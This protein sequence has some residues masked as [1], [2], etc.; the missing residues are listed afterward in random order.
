MFLLDSFKE[1]IRKEHLDGWLFCNF[2]HRDTLT[3]TLLDLDSSSVSTRRWFYFIPATGNPLKIVHSIESGILDQLPGSVKLYSQRDKL[4]EILSQFAN[5]NIAVLSDPNIHVLSTM[6]AS[7]YLLLSQVKINLCS[8]STLIQRIKGTLTKEQYLLHTR[9]ASILYKAVMDSWD[10]INKALHENTD[11]YEGDIQ[12]LMTNLFTQE[13]LITDHAPI[14]AF[15][16][17]SSDPHYTVPKA[18]NGL[19]HRGNKVERQQ[20]VQ[21]DLW[22]KYPDGVYADISWIGYTDY[23]A[24][25]LISDYFT[26]V[27]TA[28]DLVYTAIKAAFDKNQSITGADCD[29]I[30]RNFLLQKVSPLAV[31]HRTGHGIDIDCH[32]SGVNLD[33]IEF[34][35]YRK[36][37]EGS[38][39]SVEPGIYLKDFGFRTEINIAIV[40]GTAQV[41][42]PTIQKKLLLLENSKNLSF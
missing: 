30:V 6:D 31:Q 38:C 3:D 26:T 35:D 39:F 11:L 24:P 29:Q 27:I 12:D 9:A 36:I 32:G 23:Q 33:A 20:V 15:G 14:V 34:P 16:K 8:A 13:G 21:F 19:K 28:R 18:I 25:S 37:I 2:R 40:D 5:K 1:A 22:A 4:E 10:A 42:G 41:T 17:A 7:S